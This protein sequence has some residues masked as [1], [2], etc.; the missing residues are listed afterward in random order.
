MQAYIIGLSINEDLKLEKGKGKNGS[1]ARSY[2]QSSG[3]VTALCRHVTAICRQSAAICQCRNIT[4]P[5]GKACPQRLYTSVLHL[6]GILIFI[7]FQQLIIFIILAFYL[8]VQVLQQSR[9]IRVTAIELL[10]LIGTT[11]KVLYRVL[12]RVQV[13]SFL[14][15]IIL[16]R[17]PYKFIGQYFFN[18]LFII[19]I[20]L[21]RQRRFILLSW[22]I[23]YLQLSIVYLARKIG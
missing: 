8:F 4:P 18:F 7:L 22:V 1:T 21:N 13:I 6:Q 14:A 15:N 11:Y 2:I 5:S 16:Q 10:K 12:S 9:F 3:H 23:G 20:N 17:S 19:T